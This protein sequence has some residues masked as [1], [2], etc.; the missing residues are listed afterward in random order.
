VQ[1]FCFLVAYTA[2]AQGLVAPAQPEVQDQ[3]ALAFPGGGL[4]TR[5][6]TAVTSWSGCRAKCARS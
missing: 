4:Y 6:L 5:N 1:A 3:Y 2:R